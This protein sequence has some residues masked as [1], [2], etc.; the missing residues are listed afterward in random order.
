MEYSSSKKERLPGISFASSLHYDDDDDDDISEENYDDRLAN[1]DHYDMARIKADGSVIQGDGS[2]A[3]IDDS[4]NIAD[5]S[6]NDITMNCSLSNNDNNNNNYHRFDPVESPLISSGHNIST[7]AG[8]ID[9]DGGNNNSPPD[10]N[11]GSNITMESPITTMASYTPAATV[12]GG[13]VDT[14]VDSTNSASPIIPSPL[15]SPPASNHNAIGSTVVLEN[16]DDETEEEDSGEGGEQTAILDAAAAY[17]A[18]M[19]RDGLYDASSPSSYNSVSVN[20]QPE[21]TPSVKIGDDEIFTPAADDA[22]AAAVV[23]QQSPATQIEEEEGDEIVNTEYN[24]EEQQTTPYED[25]CYHDHNTNQNEEEE[26]LENDSYYI[27]RESGFCSSESIEDSDI[28]ETASENEDED[29]MD[30]DLSVNEEDENV[31]IDAGENNNISCSLDLTGIEQIMNLDDTVQHVEHDDNNVVVD[32]DRSNSDVD[33]SGID[34]LMDLNETM[35]L[36]DCSRDDHDEKQDARS[37]VNHEE[38]DRDIV[39]L[40]SSSPSVQHVDDNVEEDDDDEENADFVPSSIKQMFSQQESQFSS[41]LKSISNIQSTPGRIKKLEASLFGGDDDDV[42]LDGTVDMTGIGLSPVTRRLELV[43]EDEMEENVSAGDEVTN[44]ESALE[45][46]GMVTS[47]VGLESEFDIVD[48]EDRETSP[49][50]PPPVELDVDAEQEEAIASPPKAPVESDATT[51]DSCEDGANKSP[52]LSFLSKQSP[53]TA[54]ETTENPSTVENLETCT[55]QI[56]ATESSEYEKNEVPDSIRQMFADVDSVLQNVLNSPSMEEKEVPPVSE[57]ALDDEMSDVSHEVE[58]VLGPTDNAGEN[59]EMREAFASDSAADELLTPSEEVISMKCDEEEM[60]ESDGS[61]PDEETQQNIDSDELKEIEQSTSEEAIG[62]VSKINDEFQ[63]SAEPTFT[64]EEPTLE[65]LRGAFLAAESKLEAE[66][67]VNVAEMAENH[68]VNEEEQNV[69]VLAE[70]SVAEDTF[71]TANFSLGDIEKAVIDHSFYDAEDNIKSDVGVCA[72]NVSEGFDSAPEDDSL[73]EEEDKTSTSIHDATPPCEDVEAADALLLHADTVTYRSGNGDAVDKLDESTPPVSTSPP[74]QNTADETVAEGTP[75]EKDSVVENV[76]SACAS[77]ESMVDESMFMP[78]ASTEESS[79][80]LILEEEAVQPGV[81]DTYIDTPEDEYESEDGDDDEDF[82]PNRNLRRSSPA[83]VKHSAAP[84]IKNGKDS[85]A[86]SKK[87]RNDPNKKRCGLSTLSVNQNKPAQST[88]QGRMRPT[89]EKSRVKKDS[90]PES[91]RTKARHNRVKKGAIPINGKE[92]NEV[93]GTVAGTTKKSTYHVE[94]LERLAKPRRQQLVA[95]TLSPMKKS[96][97]T[98]ASIDR[99]S[100]LAQPRRQSIAPTVSPKKKSAPQKASIDHLS[101]LAQPRRQLVAPRLSPVMNKE[102]QKVAAGTPSFVRRSK[103]MSASKPISKST[104][105]IEQERLAQ[106]KPFKAK[107]LNG[108]EVPSRFK[109]T[110]SKPPRNDATQH[111]TVTKPRPSTTVKAPSSRLYQPTPIRNK[112]P[113]F[114]ESMQSYLTHGLR[115]QPSRSNVS[116]TLTTPKPF[117]LSSS[118]KVPKPPPASSD[119]IELQK[120]FKAKPYPFARRATMSFSQ[121]KSSEELELEECR[122]QF[123]ALPLPRSVSSGTRFNQSN[124]PYHI[125]AGQQ[126]KMAK[127]RKDMLANE[128]RETTTS[129]KARPVPR[130]TYEARKILR[131]TTNSPVRTHAHRPPR[132]SLATRAEERKLF[133]AHARELRERDA[134]VKESQLREQQ[135]WEEQELKQKRM[136]SAEDGGMCFKAREIH[137]AYM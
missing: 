7:H 33:L 66:S 13:A 70:E 57:N 82:F 137:I 14:A 97:P 1:D 105:E 30:D 26:A 36:E 28:S 56:E 116:S 68:D 110:H 101:R 128:Q 9:D 49:P 77:N 2:A 93:E 111:K 60:N 79:T 131:P 88:Q 91:Q 112:V 50:S 99:L 135:E 31:I 46:V 53:P 43:A 34:T 3:A 44:E 59:L 75:T 83:V 15:F 90:A 123:K 115:S 120:K 71:E 64:S 119:E 89:E 41:I 95:P 39:Q 80:P 47:K 10:N 124:T 58:Q 18:R 103:L 67:M 76:L 63:Q 118:H 37:C 8:D 23:L 127:E 65:C 125:K 19:A 17:M 130:S 72:Q 74:L 109:T 132:L 61:I 104:D 48:K 113:T 78:N 4:M 29:I 100:R 87:E 117:A 25:S 85:L 5:S 98:K 35:P 94:R 52:W 51:N 16:E 133:D 107:P 24:E 12:M 42:G 126:Y 69:A 45:G 129:F 86:D 38:E 27:G 55:V 21:N 73:V 114:G 22:D 121:P 102:P 134:Q 106:V 20:G 62:S 32:D 108:R 122:K 11:N 40:E 6:N 81:A 92:N 54:E 136:A 84:D 96:V